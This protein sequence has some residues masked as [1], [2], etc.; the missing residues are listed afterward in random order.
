MELMSEEEI[1]EI[2]HVFL[3]EHVQQ[4]PMSTSTKL[5]SYLALLNAYI[6]EA[7]L[8]KTEYQKILG[9]PEPIHGGPP[10]EERMKPFTYFINTSS[11]NPEQISMHTVIAQ[12]AV[13]LLAREGNFRSDIMKKFM[14]SLCGDQTQPYILPFIKDLL[15]KREMGKNGK[16]KF[17]RLIIDMLDKE[18][19]K[20]TVH[21]LNK[22][23]N[24]LRQNSIFPQTISRLYYMKGGIINYKKA[25]K[26]AKEAIKRAPKNSYVADT[27]GQIY[28][29]CLIRNANGLEDILHMAEKAFEAFKDVESK[30][31]NEEGPEMK[32]TAGTVSI[33]NSF[34]NRGLFGFIQVAKTA[35]EKL[36]KGPSYH[37]KKHGFIEKLKPEV[38]IKFDFFEWY[39]AYSKPNKTSSEPYYFWKDIVIC[40]KLYTTKNAAEST[41][42]PGLLDLLNHGLFTSKGRCVK[43]EEAE[44]TVSELEAIRDHL[45][46]TY[47]AN[48]DDVKEAERYILSNIILSNKMQNSLQHT[49][50]TELQAIIHRFLG[51]EVGHRSPQFYLLV[52]LLFWPEEEPW[53]VQ[54]EDDEEVEQKATEDDESEDKTWED[55]DSNGDQE[56][57]TEP[58]QLSLD[59]MFGP[60]LQQSV[61]FMEKAFERAKYAKYLRGRYLLPLFF[62]GTGSGLSKWI[63]RSRLDAIVEKRVDAKLA[64]DYDKTNK[65]KLRRINEM[66][67]N[68]EVWRV[69]EIQDMLLPIRVEPCHSSTMPHVHEKEQ[70]FIC[71]GG[72]KIMDFKQPKVPLL[73][74]MPYYLGF[75]IR[76]PVVFKVGHP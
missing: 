69:P 14:S 45:K 20:K 36:N 55:E 21:V 67:N 9:P 37:L 40:Y 17:S 27:L 32:D 31:E 64:D 28:K 4:N 16:G 49:P 59:L 74:P 12:R 34:N 22:A 29:N 63:H 11:P 25:E 62:L 43:F 57:R 46:T 44:E 72:Q 52:L 73:S 30:A 71:V 18:N 42:F 51:T 54:E 8:L 48:V 61:T 35:F 75:T 26:W 5:F 65:N 1:D 39:L 58:A 7:Y 41:S 70:V 76:G 47:E 6:P 24:K 10:F 3:S 13:E 2:L 23:S 50:V 66:W 56:T 15:T 60:D 33:S 38:E 19:F 53:V 68:G